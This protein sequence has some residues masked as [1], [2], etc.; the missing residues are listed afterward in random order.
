MPTLH[1]QYPCH[2]C[3]KSHAL[4]FTG[5]AAPDLGKQ[6]YYVCPTN[7]FAVRITRADGWKLAD[8]QPK[9][10]LVVHSG[11]GVGREGA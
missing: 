2:V 3:E 8:T 5:D 11:E 9:G 1:E 7:G 10:A 6:F 4:Y